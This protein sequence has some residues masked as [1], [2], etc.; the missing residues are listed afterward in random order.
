MENEFLDKIEDNAAIRIWSEKA[1]LEKGDS[2]MEGYISE[3]WDFTRV[4]V[5]QSNLQ[6]LKEIWA[7]WDDEVKQW[8]MERIKQKGESKCILWKSLQ[9][10][11]LAHPDTKK[12][13]DVLVLSIYG[14]II[15]PKALGHIDEAVSDLFDRLHRRV[16]PVPA[17]LSKTFRSLNA[18]KVSYR[19]FFE[20]YFPLKELAATPRRDDITEER[21]MSVLQNLQ[22]EDV[23]WKAP[24]MVPEEILYRCGDFDWVPL[25]GI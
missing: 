15:F 3:L 2:L 19:V 1:Q 6:E 25:L 13:V 9:D 16:T 14:L 20:I 23:E 24:W 5:T 10:L 12:K 22:D 21:W 11:I 7:Q 17:I 18:Y 4:N 8:V